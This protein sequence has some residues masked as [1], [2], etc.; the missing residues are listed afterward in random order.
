MARSLGY[1][2]P[3]PPDTAARDEIAD[4]IDALH[5]SGLARA[6]AGAIRSYPR[7]LHAVLDALDAETIRSLITLGASLRGLDP[8]TAQRLSGAMRR[9][10][11][12][13]SDAATTPEGP[14]QLW[15]RLRDPD[16]RRGLSA[17]LAAL[18]ALG[19]ALAEDDVSRR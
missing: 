15:R 8:D 6:L 19:K 12:Q 11:G 4:L 2:P 13:A 10:L 9:A 1:T 16:T 5:D 17:A 7:L 18:S 14:R 3:T